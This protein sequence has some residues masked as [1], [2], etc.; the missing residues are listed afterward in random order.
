MDMKKAVEEL[1]AIEKQISEAPSWQ[2]YKHNMEIDKNSII[3]M[4][5]H[6]SYS[7]EKNR[8]IIDILDQISVFPH[9]YVS[10]YDHHGKGPV[11]DRKNETPRIHRSNRYSN[12]GRHSFVK[13]W[14]AFMMF[15]GWPQSIMADTEMVVSSA[16][17]H[18]TLWYGHDMV[19]DLYYLC[20]IGPEENL[21]DDYV[22]KLE[23]IRRI[24][25]EIGDCYDY[26][27]FVH[28]T[29]DIVTSVEISHDTRGNIENRDSNGLVP[30]CQIPFGIGGY[31]AILKKDF[32][33]D[34]SKVPKADFMGKKR[35]VY[36]ITPTIF[37][38]ECGAFYDAEIG[39]II[40]KRK[41]ITQFILFLHE[42]SLL[43]EY[44]LK[45]LL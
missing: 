6:K 24:N 45:Y 25:V 43:H 40:G 33:W 11:N 26:H 30:V 10:F 9:Y 42:E 8:I 20:G 19:T 31:H 7:K 36:A 2:H 15:M 3:P 21:T 28:K 32:G 39:R 13:S 27:S 34:E 14:D 4:G 5:F 22:E 23:N 12:M 1:T 17:K 44:D 37:G 38:H 16:R 35:L 41:H 18:R 29:M